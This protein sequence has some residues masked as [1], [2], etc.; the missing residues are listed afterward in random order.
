MLAGAIGMSEFTPAP[1]FV[2]GQDIFGS[3]Q[4]GFICTWSGRESDGHLIAAAPDLLEALENIENN[5]GHIPETIWNMRNAAIDKARG[6][7]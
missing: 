5:S 6:K 4:N 2:R 1:W 3:E 7:A